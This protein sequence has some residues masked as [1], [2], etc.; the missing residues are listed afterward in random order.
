MEGPVPHES[1]PGCKI[2]TITRYTLSRWRIEGR[3]K[4]WIYIKCGVPGVGTGQTGIA[5]EHHI[6]R[7]RIAVGPGGIL[8][9]GS[10]SSRVRITEIPVIR[11][12]IN[13][14]VQKI[15][16]VPETKSGLG[17]NRSNGCIRA[18]HYVQLVITP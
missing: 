15:D 16:R 11:I 5:N 12:C 14:V 4:L 17:R 18:I 13:A 8:R 6:V 1:P 7:S 9:I 2:E 3:C 10:I